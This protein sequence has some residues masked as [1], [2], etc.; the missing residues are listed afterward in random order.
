M[1]SCVSTESSS[2]LLVAVAVIV[3]SSLLSVL[4]VAGQES[5]QQGVAGQL[6]FD[7][8]VQEVAKLFDVSLEVDVRQMLECIRR[9]K[10]MEL[11]A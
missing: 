9:T 5:E 10:T 11:T 1:H 4:P 7:E 2:M 8:W 3:L 6:R